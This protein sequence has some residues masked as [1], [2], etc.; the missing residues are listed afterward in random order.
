MQKSPGFVQ[1]I[2]PGHWTILASS[3]DFV[4]SFPAWCRKS[5]DSLKFVYADVNR[6]PCCRNKT[7]ENFWHNSERYIILWWPLHSKCKALSLRLALC[8]MFDMN[9]NWCLPTGLK[10]P[11]RPKHTSHLL[12]SLSSLLP[13][14]AGSTNTFFLIQEK[15]GFLI[16]RELCK[17]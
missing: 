14:E 13:A 6:A 5:G 10:R 17:G 2:W 4:V 11:R 12:S 15:L 7:K 9:L 1:Y 8:K 16:Q 3:R